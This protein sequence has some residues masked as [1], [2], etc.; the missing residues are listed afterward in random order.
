MAAKTRTP[1]PRPG[2]GDAAPPPPNT[3]STEDLAA[4]KQRAD[5]IRRTLAEVAAAHETAQNAVAAAV[6]GMRNLPKP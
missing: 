2:A 5:A 4:A 1:K 6:V 3:P